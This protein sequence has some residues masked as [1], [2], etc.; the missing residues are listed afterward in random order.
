MMSRVKILKMKTLNPKISLSALK[1]VLGETAKSLAELPQ[2]LG[3]GVIFSLR[4]DAPHGAVGEV[5]AAEVLDALLQGTV[6][7]GLG[8]LD[9]VLEEEGGQRYHNEP[10]H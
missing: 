1:Y 2:F 4:V 8:S 6:Q 10:Q 3:G 7:G 9:A 5:A